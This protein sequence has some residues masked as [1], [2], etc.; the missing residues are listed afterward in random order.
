MQCGFKHGLCSKR[1]ALSK[2]TIQNKRFVI[3]LDGG[4]LQKASFPK[5][6]NM[7]AVALEKAFEIYPEVRL[8]V[9]ANLY[10]F[11]G[12]LQ[13]LIDISHKHGDLV[14]EDAAESFGATYNGIQTGAFGDISIISFIVNNKPTGKNAKKTVRYGKN[15]CQNSQ[16]HNGCLAA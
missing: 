3:S 6:W 10:G 7:D 5:T 15:I 8:V 12:D 16:I 14:I 2:R 11:T 4:A 1:R 9:I 13:S